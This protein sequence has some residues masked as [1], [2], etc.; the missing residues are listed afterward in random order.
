MEE[1]NDYFAVM[2]KVGSNSP[3]TVQY[4]AANI[5]DAI[6]ELCAAAGV[7][8]TNGLLEFEILK[9]LPDGKYE[10]AAL[11]TVRKNDSTSSRLAAAQAPVIPPKPEAEKIYNEQTY[12]PYKLAAA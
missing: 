6:A 1:L 11:K 4:S 5:T 2:R 3:V 10:R 9:V 7:Q 12:Q 8:N